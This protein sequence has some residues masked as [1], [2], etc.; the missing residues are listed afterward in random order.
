LSVVVQSVAN[1][2]NRKQIMKQSNF[3]NHSA[4]LAFLFFMTLALPAWSQSDADAEKEQSERDGLKVSD[5][6]TLPVIVMEIEPNSAKITEDAVK[7]HVE[8][9]M[10]AAGVTLK[11]DPNDYFLLISLHVEGS[12][13]D[14][15]IGF[16]RRAS[17]ELPDGKIVHNFLETWNGGDSLGT[18]DNNDALIMKELDARLG[19]FLSAYLKANQ[20]TK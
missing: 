12:A 20:N 1:M 5:Y 11:S 15:D 13:F 10:K 14:V 17:W 9:R 6:K 3:W 18:H 8:S 4:G 7:A 16:Y 2:L 19:L